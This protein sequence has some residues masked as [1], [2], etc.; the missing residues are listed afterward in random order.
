MSQPE[1]V[2]LKIGGSAITD[3]S[4]ELEAKT[5]VI[6][7]L[8]QEIQKAE[9]KSLILVHGGGSFG[10][11]SA[12]RNSIREGFRNPN[13]L[14]GFAETHHFMTVLNG[15]VMD[16]LI[17][18]GVPAVSITPSSCMATEKGRIKVFESAPLKMLMK[19]GFL[20]VLYGDAVADTKMGF[21][22]LSG[23]QIVSALALQ[24][25]AQRIIMGVDVDGLFDTDP[26]E[27][28]IQKTATLLTHVTLDDL[29]RLTSAMDKPNDSDVTGG[30]YGKLMELMPAVEHGVSVT[31][32]N[33]A[34]EGR[35]YRAL[36]NEKVK[37]TVIEKE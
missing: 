37:G 29:R 6:N 2:I 28:D 16:S 4:G 21:T 32:T 18:N 13:Q 3:K 23:D 8:A 26:K 17:M 20:P 11:P 33:A 5:Q 19:I 1:Y 7:R 31:I 34:E 12:K 27:K 22:I 35:I 9:V 30:M 24:L 25:N 36:R 14:I 15:L 10:H